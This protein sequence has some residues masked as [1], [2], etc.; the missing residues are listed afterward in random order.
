MPA[1][2][3][4]TGAP[5]RVSSVSPRERT[6]LALTSGEALADGGGGRERVGEGRA[7]R[8]RPRGQRAGRSRVDRRELRCDAPRPLAA[9]LAAAQPSTSSPAAIATS[10]APSAAL[11]D[12][13]RKL[14]APAARARRTAGAG[15]GGSARLST[16]SAAPSRAAA[17]RRLPCCELGRQLGRC[18]RGSPAASNRAGCVLPPT[19]PRSP[20]RQWRAGAGAA[21][22]PRARQAA[23]KPAAAAVASARRCA[24]TWRRRGEAACRRR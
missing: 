4:V 20:G 19:R 11:P 16:S 10:P 15:R 9:G 24:A 22:S 12:R 21:P 2:G 23:R 17:A 5:R 6:P 1:A 18:A 7:R 13:A 3:A 8:A 14:R